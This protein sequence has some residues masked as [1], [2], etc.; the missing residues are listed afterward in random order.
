MWTFKRKQA[1]TIEWAHAETG[2]QICMRSVETKDNLAQVLEALGPELS[3]MGVTLLLKEI[4]P[5][6]EEGNTPFL[7]RFNDVPIEQVL[8][9]VGASLSICSACT[10]RRGEVTFCWGLAA[11]GVTYDAIPR[12]LL[13]RAVLAAAGFI[14]P[15]RPTAVG[16]GH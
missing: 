12:F 6:T 10:L 3:S 15:L 13:R 16:A 2:G 5:V 1:L 11:E 7:L 4:T 8:P 14:Q 9:E